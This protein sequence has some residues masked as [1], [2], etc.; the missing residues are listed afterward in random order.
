LE[1]KRRKKRE[2]EERNLQD[3]GA[4]KNN[5]KSR[6]ALH[7]AIND[8]SA[9]PAIRNLRITMNFVLVSL[10]ALAITEFVIVNN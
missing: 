8:K 2:E 9:P 6:K 3:P 1:E 7:M 5:I 10:L 4:F